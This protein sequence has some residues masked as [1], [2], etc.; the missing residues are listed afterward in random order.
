MQSEN[1]LHANDDFFI[2]GV[3]LPRCVYSCLVISQGPDKRLFACFEI[4]V[5]TNQPTQ[6]RVQYRAAAVVSDG[7]ASLKKS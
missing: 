7:E 5:E 1:I 2:L 4:C 6:N 3:L